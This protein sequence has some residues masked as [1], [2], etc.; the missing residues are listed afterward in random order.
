[1]KLTGPTADDLLTDG[2]ARAFLRPEALDPPLPEPL[3]APNAAYLRLDRPEL[4][5]DTA[6]RHKLRMAHWRS[7]EA[8]RLLAG[9]ADA[10]ALAEQLLA[11]RVALTPAQLKQAGER[12]RDVR[13]LGRLMAAQ[14]Q[15]HDDCPELHAAA[16]PDLDLEIEVNR[17]SPWTFEK[18]R[19]NPRFSEYDYEGDGVRYRG[20]LFRP[21]D[22]VL[23]NVNLEGNF[24]Y[25]LFPDPKGYCPHSAV[26]ALLE[27]DGRRWPAVI[28]TYE[29][30]LR[31]VPLNVFF[32][33]RYIS[34]AE[35]YRHRDFGPEHAG[36]FNE[37]AQR[38]LQTTRGYN[39]DT[40]DDD[41]AYVSCTT[42]ARLLYRQA[43]VGEIRARSAIAHPGLRESL[44]RIGY[45]GGQPFLAPVD[46]LLT[47]EFS[48]AGWVDNNQFDRLLT[49][50][51]VEAAFRALWA[52][53][54]L[55][56]SRM[57]PMVH[58]NHFAIRQLRRRTALGALISKVMGFDHV[59]LPKGPDLTLAA[60]EPVEAVAGRAVEKLRPFVQRRLPGHERFELDDWLTAPDV[61]AEVDRHLRVRWL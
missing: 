37:L 44:S 20:W 39:F 28:E 30:G 52:R 32:N 46:Y 40:E 53:G 54:E 1:V 11:L 38:A 19:A 23:A 15:R 56:V 14:G 31:A 59:T 16:G 7:R 41:E 21:G 43:G 48:C 51:L 4:G 27:H 36:R 26:I 3:A 9:G 25:S 33:A 12:L 2:T 29:K 61:Q 49:R 34:Y 60:I 47:P 42:V 5:A 13:L 24:V 35:I 8:E 58:V 10:G 50:E 55:E 22:V 18:W 57:P 17:S 6:L 45:T